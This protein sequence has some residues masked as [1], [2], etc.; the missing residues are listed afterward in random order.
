MGLRTREEHVLMSMSVLIAHVDKTRQEANDMNGI[1]TKLWSCSD[2]NKRFIKSQFFFSVMLYDTSC[3]QDCFNT[4]GNYN[5]QCSSGTERGDDGV[6]QEIA[7]E[8][9]IKAKH[10]HIQGFKGTNVN[11]KVQSHAHLPL[12]TN[13]SLYYKSAIC[14]QWHNVNIL[15]LLTSVDQTVQKC[16]W[17]YFYLHKKK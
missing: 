12:Y 9:D 11:V 1:I 2:W 6:C 17:V 4:V 15:N 3:T 14:E 7:G 16:I 5:C 13:F 8:C 10:S